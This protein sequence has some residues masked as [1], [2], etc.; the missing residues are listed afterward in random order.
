LTVDEKNPSQNSSQPEVRARLHPGHLLDFSTKDCGRL[1][2][3]SWNPICFLA[4]AMPDAIQ[5]ELSSVRL[6][7]GTHCPIGTAP[8]QHASWPSAGVQRALDPI[9]ALTLIGDPHIARWIEHELDR[10]EVTL[11]ISSSVAE[12]RA[13]LANNPSLR[14]RLLVVEI[15]DLTTEELL[16]IRNLRERS[17]LDELVA[18]SQHRVPSLLRAALGIDR[19]LTPPF[20]QDVFA[21][22][23]AAMMTHAAPGSAAP[24]APGLVTPP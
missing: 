15:D 12:L 7:N 19:L 23:L 14:P 6:A 17:R 4:S 10:P 8:A 16:R 22:I 2:A 9:C 20:V 11:T 24:P 21:D 3:L 5:L 13:S 18:L 1:R